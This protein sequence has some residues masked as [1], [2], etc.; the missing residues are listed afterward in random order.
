[1]LLFSV[2]FIVIIME[3]EEEA[4]HPDKN[5]LKRELLSN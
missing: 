2:I 4:R 1:L 3:Q 5:F